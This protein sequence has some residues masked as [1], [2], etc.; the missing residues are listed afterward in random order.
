MIFAAGT[1]YFIA[2]PNTTT[3]TATQ[4]ATQTSTQTVIQTTT[5][6]ITQSTNQ[7][8]AQTAG[9]PSTI[10]VAFRA[11]IGAYLTNASGWTLY[12]YSRDVPNN[13]TSACNGGCA[14]AWPPFYTVNL[15]VPPGLNSS[16]F[17]TITRTDGS[18]QLTYNGWPLY[19]YSPDKQ[20]GQ[21]NG[22]GVGG[23]WYAVSP[24]AQ[25]VTQLAGLPYFTPGIAYKSPI[26]LYLTNSSGWTLYLF[27]KDIPNNGTSACNGG[28]AK[29]WPPFYVSNLVV[30]PGINASKFT[31]ITRTDGSKQLAYNGYPLYYYAPDTKAGDTNGQGAGGVW[32][33]YSLPTPN[34][35]KSSATT[36]STSSSTTAKP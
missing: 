1:G 35:P 32:F 26:G 13:G 20:A 25:P 9:S 7:A 30:P 16:S 19:Y 36:T 18:K 15:K 2:F 3:Q 21:T 23:V 14:K 24:A 31:T 12:L 27:T 6:T 4:T 5:Q 17:N 11:P 22:Q 8:T 33:A 10:G 29:T 34:I 28:C